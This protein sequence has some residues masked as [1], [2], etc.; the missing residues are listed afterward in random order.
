MD[1]IQ[2]LKIAQDVFEQYHIDQPKMWKRMDGTPILN[3]VGVRM[4]MAFLEAQREMPAALT[5]NRF[6]DKLGT[7]LAELLDEDQWA[8]CE[9]LLINA[10]GAQ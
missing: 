6:V 1:F 3:D 9:Q 5:A 10:F 4:A 2:A 7:R 8:E